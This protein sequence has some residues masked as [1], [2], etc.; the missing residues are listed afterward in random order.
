M[1]FVVRRS[2]TSTISKAEKKFYSMVTP[3]AVPSIPGWFLLE[4][5]AEANPLANLIPVTVT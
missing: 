3:L 4:R 5:S 2:K 1:H